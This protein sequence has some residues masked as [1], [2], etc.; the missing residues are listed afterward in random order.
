M[1]KSSKSPGEDAEIARIVAALALRKLAKRV[2]LN[3]EFVF[4]IQIVQNE[5]ADPPPAYNFFSS[6]EGTGN[7]Y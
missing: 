3:E 1:R 7:F 6:E 2:G 5:Q 4:L